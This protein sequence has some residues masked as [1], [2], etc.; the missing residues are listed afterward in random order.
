LVCSTAPYP[1][2]ERVAEALLGERSVVLRAPTGAGK[3]RA[4][5]LPFLIEMAKRL[6]PARLICG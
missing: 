6:G 5:I 2:Q 4:A 3:V 1:Y